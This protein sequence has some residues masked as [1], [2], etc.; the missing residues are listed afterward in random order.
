MPTSLY[1]KQSAVNHENTQEDYHPVCHDVC[2]SAFPQISLQ[3]ELQQT[4]KGFLFSS[5][6]PC[7]YRTCLCDV[8]AQPETGNQL[9]L[10]INALDI[11]LSS[12]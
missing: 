1:N 4:L 7:Y 5:M 3:G 12:Y 10:L 8:T 9:F 2:V 6:V 11:V